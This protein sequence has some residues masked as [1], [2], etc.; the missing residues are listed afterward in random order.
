MVEN[1]DFISGYNKALADVKYNTIKWATV[2]LRE[3]GD[4]Y[5]SKETSRE[6]NKL[7]SRLRK[8]KTTDIEKAWYKAGKELV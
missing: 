7:C 6:I 1:E 4:P 3:H 8:V 2:S 5:L